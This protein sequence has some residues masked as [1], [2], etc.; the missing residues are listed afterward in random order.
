MKNKNNV[1]QRSLLSHLIGIARL[2]SQRTAGGGSE[3]TRMVCSG[4]F[5]PGPWLDPFLGHKCSR[6]IF[7]QTKT[8]SLF[9]DGFCVVLLIFVDL[10]KTY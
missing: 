10:P 7:V 5:S 8:Y 9:M 4:L 6:L 2:W 1:S 3:T